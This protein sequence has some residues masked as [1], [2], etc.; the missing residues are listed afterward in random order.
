MSTK[1]E[2]IKPTGLTNLDLEQ[3][4]ELYAVPV[5][6]AFTLEMNQKRK[7]ATDLLKIK[8]KPKQVFFV[9]SKGRDSIEKITFLGWVKLVDGT[10]GAIFQRR[11]GVEHRPGFLLGILRN[12]QAPLEG[13]YL[14]RAE[15]EQALK[16][17]YE[18]RIADLTER[19]CCSCG[20]D[21]GAP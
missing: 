13:Y 1:P 20:A 18:N 14:E 6:N 21:H 17:Y 16:N 9:V 2:R 8:I 15:A 10:D 5:V 19:S 3:C 7:A 4:R 12:N 11:Q